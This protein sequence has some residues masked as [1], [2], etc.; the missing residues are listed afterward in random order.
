MRRPFAALALI[1]LAAAA[2]APSATP[3]PSAAPATAA[4]PATPVTSATPAAASATPV[5]TPPIGIRPS[6]P[7]DAPVISDPYWLVDRGTSTSTWSDKD[8]A[9]LKTMTGRTFGVIRGGGIEDGILVNGTEVALL[10][11]HSVT[12][13]DPIPGINAIEEQYG[14]QI[15]D[16]TPDPSLSLTSPT[17]DNPDIWARTTQA[18]G[19]TTVYVRTGDVDGI[20]VA[21]AYW[22]GAS[23][24]EFRSLTL[25]LD[26]SEDFDALLTAVLGPAE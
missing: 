12:G 7:P 13:D 14:A 26:S 23:P 10:S 20:P 21:D 19:G 1:V 3:A 18:R 25:Q 11:V 17:L 15:D 9:V 8:G 16:A 22:W 5:L 6:L 4:V 24:E 2:C